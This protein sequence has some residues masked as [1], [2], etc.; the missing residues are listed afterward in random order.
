MHTILSRFSKLL[1]QLDDV[2][3][4][5]VKYDSRRRWSAND[6]KVCNG[7]MNSRGNLCEHSR[8]RQWVI[9]QARGDHCPLQAVDPN[10][11]Y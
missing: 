5:A 4:K 7:V 3:G 11:N 9:F 10:R 2:A 1:D 8:S 6:L